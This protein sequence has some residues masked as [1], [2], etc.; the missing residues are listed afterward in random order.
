LQS[1]IEKAIWFY[2]IYA[3]K[4]KVGYL[5]LASACPEKLEYDKV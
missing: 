5:S 1:I 2:K 3:P 4:R